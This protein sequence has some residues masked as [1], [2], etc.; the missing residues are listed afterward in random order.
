MS[1]LGFDPALYYAGRGPIEALSLGIELEP[2]QAALRCNLVSV[3]D[4]LMAHYAA[5]NISSGEAGELVSSLQ[6]SLGD[7]RLALHRGVGFRNI[8]TVR[9][10]QEVVKTS[11]VPA[12]DIQGRPI[13]EHLPQ[14]PAASLLVDLIERS[15]EILGDHPV[16]RRR[17]EQDLLPATALWPFWPGMQ[18]LPMPS[19]A[20]TYGCR[21]A[22]TSAV[23]LLK[24]LARQ[25]EIDF[26]EIA[27]VTDGGDNDYAAQMSGALRGLDDHDLVVVHV[28]APDEAG[29][30]GDAEAKVRSLEQ[31]DSL[32]LSQL[33]AVPGLRLLVMPDHPTPLVL[34]THV[35]EDVP[36]LLWG[37]GV[38]ANGA[39]RYTESE[40]ARS[41]LLVDPGRLLMGR[42]LSGGRLSGR[43]LSG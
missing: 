18:A 38:R 1:V 2:G 6:A 9:D 30:S 39:A 3:V 42:L 5:G 28:E 20:D 21:A 29:H 36:F 19:F 15:Q 12:H 41:G 35:A 23:D 4:G 22:L 10:G 33:S 13:S 34:R 40:A 25:A 31:V 16:N 17:R 43:R 24:G 14:G 37:E 11:C 8:L 32:M 27:G 26:L 7:G